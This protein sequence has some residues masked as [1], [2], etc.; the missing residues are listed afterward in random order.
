MAGHVAAGGWR[1]HACAVD[2]AHG[3]GGPAG[4]WTGSTG[5]WW[6]GHAGAKPRSIVD[7]AWGRRAA[8]RDGG[9]MAAA[10]EVAG[11]ALRGEAEHAEGTPG[12]GSTRR[13]RGAAHLR[14]RGSGATRATAADRGETAAALQASARTAAARISKLGF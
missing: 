4:R 7:R 3:A 8:G 5:P 2:R 10:G 12:F 11:R 9:A 6:T 1:V 13:G 14:E